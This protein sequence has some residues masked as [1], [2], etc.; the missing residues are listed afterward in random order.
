MGDSV[1]VLLDFLK[2]R[3]GKTKNH[4]LYLLYLFPAKLK[5]RSAKVDLLRSTW[6]LQ[7]LGKSAITSVFFFKASSSF[8]VVKSRGSGSGVSLS[9]ENNLFP[10]NV[11]VHNAARVVVWNRWSFSLSCVCDRKSCVELVNK[12]S[13]SPVWYWHGHFVRNLWN[14]HNCLTSRKWVFNFSSLWNSNGTWSQD[15]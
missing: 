14:F 10:F 7:R 11:S 3:K 4:L 2:L 15:S 5:R 8:F 13:L 12:I 6:W 1:T 9:Y